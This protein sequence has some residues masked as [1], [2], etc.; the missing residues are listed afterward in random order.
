MWRRHFFYSKESTRTTWK[1][2][3]GALVVVM[4][5]WMVTS[6]FW[7]TEIARSLVCARDVTPSDVILIE[8]FDPNYLLFARAAALEKAGLARRALVTVQIY[9]A[10]SGPPVINP[11]SQGIAEVMARQARIGVWGIIPIRETEPISLNAAAQIR[12]HLAREQVKSLIVVTTGFRSRR[13]LLIYRAVLNGSDVQ[14]RCD[15]VFGPTTPERWTNTWHGIEEVAQQFLKLQYY[16]FYVLPFSSR[17]SGG[18]A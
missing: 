8:N 12:E 15:P 14:V 3:I 9:Q 1:L 7:T 18:A 4:L 10:P 6:G 2:R 11:V 17:A 13:S 16:R 5:I